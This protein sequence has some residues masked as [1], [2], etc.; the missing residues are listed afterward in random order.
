MELSH[1]HFDHFAG[2]V[3]ILKRIPSSPSFSSSPKV[4]STNYINIFAHPDSFLRRWEVA[5]DGKRAKCPILDE[6]QLQELGAKICKATG[7]FITT[8]FLTILITYICVMVM[9]K[10][11]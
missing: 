1:G 3:N 2:L 11:R 9:E 4:S 6:I 5:P 10:I 7:I 8:K